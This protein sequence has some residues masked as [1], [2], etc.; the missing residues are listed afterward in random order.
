VLAKPRFTA[1]HRSVLVNVAYYSPAQ[2]G[3]GLTDGQAQML[4]SA[5]GLVFD[6]PVELRLVRLSSPLMDGNVLAQVCALHGNKL[7]F[8]RLMAQLNAMLDCLFNGPIG[9]LPLSEVTGLRV[10]LSGRL[11][12][13]RHAPRQTVSYGYVGNKHEQGQT[14]L[15]QFTAKNKLGAFTVK[16]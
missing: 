4:A 14:D 3:T 16:V 8:N 1:S 7:S 5:L 12:T 13:Q 6:L 9:K 11:T 10:K 15:G 2:H